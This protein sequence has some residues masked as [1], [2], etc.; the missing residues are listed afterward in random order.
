ML[1][2][3]APSNSGTKHLAGRRGYTDRLELTITL[4]DFIDKAFAHAEQRLRRLVKARDGGR[5]PH[6][7]EE[8]LA[9]ANA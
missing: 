9:L 2:R 6:P 8:P 1:I 5:H 4:P 7:R 3:P